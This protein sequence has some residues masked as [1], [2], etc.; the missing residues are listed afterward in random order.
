MPLSDVHVD[1]TGRSFRNYHAADYNLDLAK[2]LS[3][4]RV[5]V[6]VAGNGNLSFVAPDSLFGNDQRVHS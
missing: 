6:I 5:A 4:E 3:F 1:F 2:S